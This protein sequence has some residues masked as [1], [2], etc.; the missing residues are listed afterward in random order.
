M[1][2]RKIIGAIISAFVCL[3]VALS[4]SALA[5]DK[6]E[7]ATN[8]FAVP[9]DAVLLSAVQDNIDAWAEHYEISSVL[10]SNKYCRQSATRGYIVD[11]A[12]EIE[13]V[14]AYESAA[15][16]PHV[17][18]LVEALGIQD[19]EASTQ[20][21]L[22]EIETYAASNPAVG[23]S[24]KSNIWQQTSAIA[25]QQTA[26]FISEIVKNLEDEYIGVSNTIYLEF[27]AFFTDNN[28]LDSIY[29]VA[30]DGS[31]YDVELLKPQSVSE[32]RLN[33][34]N[35]FEEILSAAQ[36]AAEQQTAQPSATVTKTAASVATTAV[37]HRVTARD[38]ANSWTSN[39]ASPATKD[40]SQWRISSNPNATAPLY[41]ANN[42]D[43]ANY[44]SQAIFAGGIPKTSTSISDNEHWFASQYGCSVAWESCT[45]MQHYF[46]TFAGYW[47]LSNFT[48]CNAGGVIFFLDN[49]GARYHVVMCVQNDTVTR[50][51]SAH[52][53]DKLAVTYTSSASFGA[54][55][56]EYYVFA[57]SQAD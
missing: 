7:I 44:V 14:L 49:T 48:N 5:V 54:S 39:P 47:T 36:S 16:L 55:S 6:S 53:N 34:A 4:E 22:A 32:M 50:K 15:K 30:Y 28:K 9:S 19:T 25:I 26:L 41:P 31:N 12:V 24:V 3:T 1:K 37:Y 57:N 43:C 56:V 11:F 29:A 13:G 18:G 20:E 23:S 38:Y 42:S 51:Y 8:G 33:G 40:I 10:V 45:G 35:Q 2:K 17:Q 27:R 52:T 46:Y 21:L